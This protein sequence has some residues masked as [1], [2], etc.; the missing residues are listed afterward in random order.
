MGNRKQELSMVPKKLSC[1][2]RCL[3]QIIWGELLQRILA[4]FHARNFHLGRPFGDPPKCLWNPLSFVFVFFSCIFFLWTTLTLS[5]VRSP[6]SPWI[7]TP[8]SATHFPKQQLSGQVFYFILMPSLWP[9]HGSSSAL[10][11]PFGGDFSEQKKNCCQIYWLSFVAGCI[12][13]YYPALS[14][15]WRLFVGQIRHTKRTRPR[16]RRRD[17]LFQIE[18]EALRVIN[19]A[20]DNFR[21]LQLG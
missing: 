20:L 11:F 10:S 1:D 5:T 7:P 16:C 8:G 9:L 2:V 13:L 17:K 12:V 14:V 19:S 18:Q 15:R 21:E 3:T 6:T 4:A